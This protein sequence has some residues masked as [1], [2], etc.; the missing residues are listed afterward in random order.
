MLDT[1]TLGLDIDLSGLSASAHHSVCVLHV[2]VEKTG[3]TSLQRFMQMNEAELARRGIWVPRSLVLDPVSGPFNHV[4]LETASHLSVAQPDDL[5]S[6]L[7][8]CSMA[9]V[10]AHRREVM[11]NL[12]IERAGLSYTPAMIMVSSEH[13]QSRLNTETD[14]M[15]ARELLSRFCTTFRVVVY[16]RRQD[17]LARSLAV[18]SVRNGALEC[19]LIPDFCSGNGFDEVLGVNYDYFDYGKLLHRLECV[20]GVDALDVRL[21]DEV[22]LVNNNIIEDFFGRLDQDIT[23]L[24]MPGRENGSL[25]PLA[26]RFLTTINRHLSSAPNSGPIRERILA[27]LALRNTGRLPPA[28]HES[29]AAFMAQFEASNE[30]IR[31]RWFPDRENLFSK[32]TQ[33]NSINE[34][35]QSEMSDHDVMEMLRPFRGSESIIRWIEDQG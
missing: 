27:E 23:D 34:V 8:L 21:Y 22:S 24:P 30:A 3:T 32:I 12:E 26:V 35:E 28:A 9:M 25:D 19:R 17:E 20:F 33:T 6:R 4:L 18:T 13:V 7:G 11:L 16:L 14:L 31:K 29:T 1:T 15:L 2:G 10:S 5:Q